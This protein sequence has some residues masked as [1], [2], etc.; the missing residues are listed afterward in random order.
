MSPLHQSR[1]FITKMQKKSRQITENIWT[2]I[3]FSRA[4][5]Q[6]TGLQKYQNTNKRRTENQITEILITEIHK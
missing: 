4:D 1:S 3:I 6:I 2:E 5:I